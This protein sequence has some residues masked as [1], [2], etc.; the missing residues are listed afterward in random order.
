MKIYTVMSFEYGCLCSCE[1][2]KNKKDAIS[3]LHKIITLTKD[4]YNDLIEE[5]Y[6]Q[7]GNGYEIY[8]R[9]GKVK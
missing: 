1:H 4:E 6:Y 7:D 3:Y 5:G 9:H 8:F 2:F